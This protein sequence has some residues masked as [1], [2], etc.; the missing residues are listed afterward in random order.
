MPIRAL[1]LLI[2]LGSASLFAQADRIP[3]KYNNI[4]GMDFFSL[5]A[6]QASEKAIA[7]AKK[8]FANGIYRTFISG[9]PALSLSIGEMYLQEYSIYTVPIAGCNVSEGIH[10]AEQGY[11]DTMKP[12]LIK[13]FGK[14]IFAEAKKQEEKAKP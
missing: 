9:Q 8:D 14:D 11:N 12:L 1:L 5:S 4:N 3:E 6:K 2:L 10:G 13:K 7:L